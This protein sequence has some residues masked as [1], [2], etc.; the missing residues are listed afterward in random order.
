MRAGGSVFK[1]VIDSTHCVIEVSQLN[2][3]HPLVSRGRI[4]FIE[5]QP[6]NIA[7]A[8]EAI[9]KAVGETLESHG[10]S[11]EVPKCTV[12]KMIGAQGKTIKNTIQETG[13]EL[14]FKRSKEI[15]EEIL[16]CT[17]KESTSKDGLRS[18][19]ETLLLASE[20][21]SGAK[22]P[23]ER[24]RSESNEGESEDEG[25]DDGGDDR[26]GSSSKRPRKRARSESDGSKDGDAGGDSGDEHRRGGGSKDGRS[27]HGKS[28]KASRTGDHHAKNKTGKIQHAKKAKT[29]ASTKKARKQQKKD[30]RKQKGNGGNKGGRATGHSGGEC[31][32][33]KRGKRK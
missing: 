27:G 30:N 19:I 4:I 8:V 2:S 17:L 24:A 14:Q 7:D 9:Y 15:A 23:C 6:K 29:V 21:D 16:H 11:F 1:G 3:F 18:I 20:P 25:G 10:A 33:N 31:G 32:E 12:K 5:G 28:V 22:R 13:V 26:G